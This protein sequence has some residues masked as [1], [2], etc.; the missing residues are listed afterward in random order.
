MLNREH[1]LEQLHNL[2]PRLQAEYSV[3]R[4]GLFGSFAADEARA[5]I[6]DS[7]KRFEAEPDKPNF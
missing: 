1:I 4:I 7:V 5:E 3:E 6:M 2:L